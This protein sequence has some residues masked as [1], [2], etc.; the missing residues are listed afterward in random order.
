[1]QQE[2]SLYRR[3]FLKLMLIVGGLAGCRGLA[4]DAGPTAL[5]TPAGTLPPTV[6]F[7]GRFVLQNEA[8][9]YAPNPSG[10][11]RTT[12]QGVV[13]DAFGAPVPGAVIRVWAGD[14]ASASILQTDA[15][16][17]YSLDV[18][19][20]LTETAYSLQLVDP[21]GAILLSDVIIAQAIPSC[22][23]NL[24]TVNFVGVP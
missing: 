1:M 14:P 11:N 2:S 9:G 20:N 21:S 18:A 6:A 24:L 19:D 10:C 13:Q 8:V 22:D 7:S 3:Q 17:V 23:L 12:L 4:Q 16:G 5:A 15:Q